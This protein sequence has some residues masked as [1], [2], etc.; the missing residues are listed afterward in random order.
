MNQLGLRNVSF[1]WIPLKT[2]NKEEG[3]GLQAID[4][5][6]L[7]FLYFVCVSC[8]ATLR[9]KTGRGFPMGQ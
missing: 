4:P 7:F 8:L 6:H 2:F 9:D 5:K 3:K 1:N